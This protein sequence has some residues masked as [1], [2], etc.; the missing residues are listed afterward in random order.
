MYRSVDQKEYGIR[1]QQYTIQ[2]KEMD[3]ISQVDVLHVH[4][5]FGR[6]NTQDNNSG[7]A[8]IHN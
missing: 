1:T 3:E 2:F 5:G 6:R 8:Y 4:L 7:V